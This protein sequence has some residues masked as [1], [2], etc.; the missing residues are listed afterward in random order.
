M[1]DSARRLRLMLLCLAGVLGGVAALNWLA[2]PYG[3]WRTR[4]IDPA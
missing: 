3:A 2:N 4:V 1:A